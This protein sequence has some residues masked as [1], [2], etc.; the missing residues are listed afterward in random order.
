M[1]QTSMATTMTIYREGQIAECDYVPTIVSG[2]ASAALKFG[3]LLQRGASERLFKPMDALPAAD[4]D[5]IVATP[6]ASA[7]TATLVSG[8]TLMDGVVGAGKVPGYSQR[9][10]FVLNNHADWDATTMKVVYENEHG[11]E[12]H[13]DVEIP[14]GGNTTVYTA[15]SVSVMKYFIIPAQS[16]TNGTLTA[17]LEPTQ[18]Y[19]GVDPRNF[20]GIAVYKP[21][22]IPYAATTEVAQYDSIS[23]LTKGRV[24]VKVEKAV[25]VG[26]PAYVRVVTSGTD[27]R[28]QWQGEPDTNF[29]R[30]PGASFVTAAAI[31]GIAVLELGGAS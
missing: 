5:A 16:G 6:I 23:V 10:G 30:Y 7:V 19:I 4:V 27:V 14:N 15:G 25:T 26:A 13:E 24:A 8:S 2:N 31:D 18:P 9:V 29:V 20:P 3:L 1:S 17:G 28:G 21:M 22:Q 12:V 11:V